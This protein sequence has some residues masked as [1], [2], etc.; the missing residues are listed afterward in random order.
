MVYTLQQH[1]LMMSA[2]NKRKMDNQENAQIWHARLGHISQDRIRRLVNS[3]ILEI[4]DLDHLLACR[5]CLKGKITKKPF[6]GQRT[7]A[8]N[9]LDL[10]YLNVCGPLNTQ[11]RGGFFYF[12]T[13]TDDHSQYGYVYLMRYNSEAFGRF[14]EFR[15]EVENQ[16]DRKIKAL[17][18]DR[19]GGT[20]P[21]WTMKSFI[22]LPLSSWGYTL[23]TAAKLLNM[24]PT[25]TMTKTP[26]LIWH[27][28]PAS[29]KY[30]GVWGS[31][32]YVKR[33]IGDKVDLRSSLCSIFEKSFP[34]DTRCELLLL[35][36]SSGATSQTDAVTSSAHIVPTTIFLSFEGRPKYPNNLRDPT[37]GVKPVECKWV[38]K[39]KLGADRKVTTFKTR[40]VAKWYTQQ[41]R[42]DFEETYSPIAMAK[43][44]Q[45]M[46]ATAAW[47]NYEIWQMDVKTAFLNGFIE[48]EIYIDQLEGFTSVGEEHKNNFDPCIYK[49]VSGCSVAFL[50]LYVND[51]LLIGNDVK[52]LAVGSI[53]YVVQ[54]IRPDV[55]F[56]LSVTNIYQ[57]CAGEAHWL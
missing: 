34:A 37:K 39:R 23:E 43:S 9:L 25:N 45:I 30:L 10:I 15:L 7:L 3:K 52:I 56:A 29:Y 17:R 54:C 33:L 46:R 48:E 47:Y 57:T 13:F 53:Q 32:A 12:I 55:A 50:V 4:D 18:S 49:K 26:H 19:G 28:K 27:D 2:Q 44:T 22:E 40:I 36:E 21:C 1:D 14:K 5:S 31:L 6:V 16:T 8:S 20:E 38:Y 42:V 24:V 35:E 11:A 51:I 41:P